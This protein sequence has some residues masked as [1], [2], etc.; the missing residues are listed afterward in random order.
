MTPFSQDPSELEES[1]D[2]ARLFAESQDKPVRLEPGQAIEAP[3]VNITREWVFI[4]TGRKGEGVLDRKEFTA[5]DGTLTV[6]AGDRIKA[7]FLGSTGGEMRF[8]TR[9]GDSGGGSGLA[10]LEE[11]W[12]SGIPVDG[13]VEKEIKGGLEIKLAGG[14]RAFCPFSQ[15]DIRR[16]SET[17]PLVGSHFAF[18]VTQ[19]GEKGRNVVVSRRQLLE[20][21]A[22]R[23]RDALREVWRTGMI[24]RGAVTSLKE[25]GAF[26]D[27]DGIEG[28]IPISEIGWGRIDNPAD[29]LSVGQ[30]VDVVIKSLDW[31]KRRF[32]FSLRETLADPWSRAIDKFREG[33]F[34]H[35][36]VS[37]LATFGAFVTLEEGIDG[38]LHISQLGAGRRISHPREVIHEGDRVEV[39]ILG[40]DS[41]ARR[42]SLTLAAQSRAAEEE[43]GNI[44]AFRQD[45]AREEAKGMGTFADLLRARTERGRKT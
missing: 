13:V 40:V 33:T 42:I 21:E 23:Q 29:V 36:T 37:R 34:H 31:E 19:F 22:Q 9:L 30:S 18:R 4:D 2:F 28:L 25:F 7:F 12:R 5:A 41:S 39:K 11:A 24:V 44:A 17:A 8:T 45:N 1:E 14:H 38:L 6:A 32:S 26:L 16:I 35:G 15:F 27:V 10:L 20:E 3:V 43:A